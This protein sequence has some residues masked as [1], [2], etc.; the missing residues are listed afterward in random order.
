MLLFWGIFSV[1]G[2]RKSWKIMTSKESEKKWESWFFVNSCK[3]WTEYWFLKYFCTANQKMKD[4]D[5]GEGGDEGCGDG[6][7]EGSWWS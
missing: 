5:E 7:N 3:F 6:G 4:D 1:V 2:F